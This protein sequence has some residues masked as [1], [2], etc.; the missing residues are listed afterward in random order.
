MLVVDDDADNA[1]LLAIVLGRAG[2][3]V[4]VCHTAA[5][6]LDAAAARPPDAVL[7]DIGLP[8]MD[9]IELYSRLRETPKNGRIVG[10][11][12]TGR[13]RDERPELA[14]LGLGYARKPIDS[15]SLIRDLAS[16]LADR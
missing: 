6:A 8:D 7:F 10:I 3:S 13:A 2:A 16:R 5:G 14:E 12:V 15:G 4:E 11:A 1:E 9:G